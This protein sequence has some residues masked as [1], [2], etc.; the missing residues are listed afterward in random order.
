MTPSRQPADDPAC[1]RSATSRP[2]FPIR[3]GVVKAVD[4]VVLRRSS[5]ARRSAS[6]ANPARGKSVTARSILQ[7]VDAP[8]RIV[9]RL[10]GAARAPT[11]PA[12]TSPG[13]IRAAARSAPCAAREIAMIFQEPMSS[14]SPV[15]TRRRPDHRGAAAASRHGARQRQRARAASSCCGRS[16]SPTPETRHRPLH[17]R[18]LRRHAPARDD[19]DGARLQSVSC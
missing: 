12:S 4:G 6:S 10:D 1:S 16:R 2:S 17:L 7:I 14:L 15:H 3:T 9:S 5:A 11:A 8:G 19:R 18:V 13:S